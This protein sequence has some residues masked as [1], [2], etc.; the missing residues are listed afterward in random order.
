MSSHPP[1]VPPAGRSN[2]GVDQTRQP[3]QADKAASARPPEKARDPKQG[4]QGA[5][6][7]NTTNPGFQQD[8]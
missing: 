4:R 8:R 3:G 2:K 1:P 5:V 7:Q 6:K